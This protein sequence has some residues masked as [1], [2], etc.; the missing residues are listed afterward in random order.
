MLTNINCFSIENNARN[1]K[2]RPLHCMNG[3]PISVLPGFPYLEDEFNEMG[4]PSIRLHDCFGLCDIDNSFDEKQIQQILAN[5]DSY[6]NKLATERLSDMMTYRSLVPEYRKIENKLLSGDYSLQDAEN[7]IVNSINDTHSNNLSPTI[8][9]LSWIINNNKNKNPYLKRDIMFRVGRTLGGGNHEIKCLDLYARV[10][11]ELVYKFT[12]KGTLNIPDEYLNR[13]KYW[14][15]WN[16]PN[17]GIFWTNASFQKYINLYVKCYRNIKE[18]NPSVLVGGS[19]TA[20]G[21]DTEN[22]YVKDFM[23]SA[24]GNGCTP[25]FLSVHL[26]SSTETPFN[27]YVY[28]KK[29]K[30]K[31]NSFG[32][33]EVI[34]SEWAP[35]WE[36]GPDYQDA[37][38]SARGAAYTISAMIMMQYAGIDR[39]YYYRGDGGPLGIFNSS[40][41]ASY[42]AQAIYLFNQMF[43]T[44]NVA[45]YPQDPIETD[46]KN[47]ISALSGV[48]DDENLMNILIST[49]TLNSGNQG[50]FIKPNSSSQRSYK[51]HYFDFHVDKYEDLIRKN[52]TVLLDQYYGSD[53]RL[54]CDEP[55][56]LN[57][58]R[59]QTG[60]NPEPVIL[61]NTSSKILLNGFFNEYELLEIYGV[62]EGGDLNSIIPPIISGITQRSGN[63]LILNACPDSVYL[64]KAQ[65]N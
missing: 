49:Y 62:V 33:K 60:G 14:E 12:Y 15:I 46:Y 50:H 21:Y 22:I 23:M 56:Q 24:N 29:L 38:Q 30:D 18:A 26:Y 37:Y 16:E 10:V 17:L 34:V 36:A 3:T 13:V 52:E 32:I 31:A 25:D 9:L 61:Q 6:Y 45:V 51:Q 19:A 1:V 43:E 28:G 59:E 2:L 5:I 65:R 11:Q 42:T 53:I 39:A 48:S 8:N 44:S 40:N 27:F 63:D 58:T 20:S 4:I 57:D 47:G 54:R 7:L 41:P 64:I 55:A 35:Y